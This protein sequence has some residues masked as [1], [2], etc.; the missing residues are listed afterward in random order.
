MF[1]SGEVIVTEQGVI[2][3]KDLN[4]K[5]NAIVIQP[6]MDYGTRQR[7]IG[8]ATS[9]K[10]KLS[11]NRKQRRAAK[12]RGEKGDAQE[13]VMDVGVYQIALL[14][15]NVIRWQGP[16]FDNMP[17]TPANIERLNPNEPLV[18]RVL[19]EI[20]ERNATDDEDDS[21]EADGPNA[22]VLEETPTS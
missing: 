17:C 2:D 7:V 4:A 5:I 16:A 20:G 14:V 21:D 19:E 12:A 18:K 1:V 10:V 11:G 22:L 9:V 3:E 13:A 15:H 8:A 6:T